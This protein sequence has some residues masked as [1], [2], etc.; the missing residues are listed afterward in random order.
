MAAT[1]TLASVS[2][3]SISPRLY[4]LQFECH[5]RMTMPVSCPAR[6]RRQCAACPLSI[7][8]FVCF[9]TKKEQFLQ[10]LFPPS[11][12][13]LWNSPYNLAIVSCG[14]DTVETGTKGF[15]KKCFQGNTAHYS[16]GVQRSSVLLT[17]ST[18][19]QHSH[20][21]LKTVQTYS[22]ETLGITASPQLLPL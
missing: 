18:E 11:D 9:F 16:P 17:L 20:Q 19:T 7:H 10:G 14:Q 5:L 1:K 2:R 12:S 21:V 15:S 3:Y 8:L 4:L 22:I 13:Q 6:E